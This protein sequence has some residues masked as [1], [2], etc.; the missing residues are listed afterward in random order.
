MDLELQ[1]KVNDTIEQLK[2]LS[3]DGFDFQQMDPIAKM[4]FVALVYEIQKIYD[5]IDSVD[6]R[7]VE[8]YCTDFIPRQEVEAMPAI[9]LLQPTFK[10]NKDSE[11]VSVGSGIQFSYK[12]ERRK[13]PINYIP[14]FNTFTLPYSELF[15]VHQDNEYCKSVNMYK[16]NRLWI[17][18]KTKVEVESIKGLSLFIKGTNGIAPEHIYAGIDSH[19][20]DFATPREMEQVEMA[21]PFDVQQASGQFFSFLG[22]WKEFLLNMKEAS[23]LFITDETKSRDIFKHRAYPK[24]FE[25]WNLTDT[26]EQYEKAKRL[27]LQIEFPEGYIVPNDCEVMLNVIPVV[28]VDVC[29]LTLSDHTP[30]AK[31]Q[32]QEDSFFLRILDTSVASNRQGFSMLNDEI[33][34]RDFDASCYHNGDLYRDMRNLYNKFIDDY[35]AFMEYNDIKDDK[36]QKLLRETINKI[37]NNN[38]I[39]EPNKKFK[40]DSGTY[41]MKNLRQNQLSSSIKVNYITTQGEIGNLPHA[42]E[43][44]E[45]K[46]IPIFDPKVP[47]IV[48]AMGGDDKASADERY[49][50][51]RYYSLTNDRLYT[52]M[53]IDAF[54]RKEIM[55]VFG[56][57]EFKRIII[58]ISIEGF[59]GTTTVQ[60][61]LYIDISFK[62]KKNYERAIGIS[63]DK[64]IQQRIE[65]KSCISMPIIVKLRNLEE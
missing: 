14:L 46:K 45:N 59:G 55:V 11:G 10:T 32:K 49:E 9:T 2:L 29:S 53:D 20:L 37:A 4:M 56:K 16:P 61:G 17:G 12:T 62:D 33:I 27:W 7:I 48:S 23:L 34:V 63:F 6:Q 35:Y 52:K 13:Q 24:M 43:M 3:I 22:M 39:K 5:H 57:E 36:T 21:E 8:R 47:I 30:I 40:F 26:L 28:N 19:E 25:Q 60:R 31:L 54:L 1:N 38:S 51:L 65:N 42:G 15:V 44:M 18:I 50:L 64:L 41:V 58:N